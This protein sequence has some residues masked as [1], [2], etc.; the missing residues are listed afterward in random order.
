MAQ[1]VEHSGSSKHKT[2]SSNPSIKKT[3]RKVKKKKKKKGSEPGMVTHTCY[4]SYLE[5]RDWG[6]LVEV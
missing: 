2:L 1:V 3:E 5:G 6:D 4:L